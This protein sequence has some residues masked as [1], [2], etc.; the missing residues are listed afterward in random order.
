MASAKG[1]RRGLG[2][3]AKLGKEF[4]GTKKSFDE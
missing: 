2:D 3:K 4:T 1:S